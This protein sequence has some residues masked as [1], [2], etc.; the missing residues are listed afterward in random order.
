MLKKLFVTLMVV[1]QLFI[2]SGCGKEDEAQKAEKKSSQA[3]RTVGAYQA[4]QAAQNIQISGSRTPAVLSPGHRMASVNNL[5]QLGLALE[6][7]MNSSTSGR[8]PNGVLNGRNALSDP[9]A[10]FAIL[11]TD[12][13]MSDANV[14]IAP[15]DITAKK[16][17]PGREFTF[18]NTSYVYIYV[19][20][21]ASNAPVMFEKPWILPEK[22][23]QI[24]VLYADGHVEVKNIQDVSKKSCR[25]VLEIL[26]KNPGISGGDA[27]EMLRYA[28]CADKKR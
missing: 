13:H 7:Y 24:A 2:V 14:Y 25:E 4:V 1:W 9:A 20:A 26:L 18:N 17:I 22:A 5:K 8:R 3:S 15:F 6:I 19:S 28:D 27:Q 12:G 11:F 21:P 23:N 16:A 10:A